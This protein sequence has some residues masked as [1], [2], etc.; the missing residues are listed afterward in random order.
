MSVAVLLAAA[1]LFAHHSFTAAYDS[2]KRVEIEGVVKEFVWRNPHSFVRIEV[3]T[4]EGATEL[5]NLE[6]GSTTQL[7]AAKYPVTTD[8]DQGRR[9]HHRGRR[10]GTRPGR[11]ARPHL[12]HQATD[13]RLGVGRVL[14]TDR[15]AG[16]L[17]TRRKVAT[18]AQCGTPRAAVL[19]GAPAST[20]RWRR[21][22]AVPVLRLLRSPARIVAP[23]DLTGYWVSVVAEHWHLRMLVPP[24]GEFAML[25]LNAEARK[26]ANAWDPAKEPEA[27][28]CKSYGAAAIMRVPGRLYIHWA[29][30]NTLQMDVDS[31]TQT[32]VFH[33]DRGASPTTQPPVAGIFSRG[34]GRNS[35]AGAADAKSWRTARSPRRPASDDHAHARGV[36]AQ[37]RRPL[38]R[39]RDARR[40]LRPL[41][42]AQRRRLDRRRQHRHRP[43]IPDAAVSHEQRVQ[44]DS[45]SIRLGSDALPGRSGQIDLPTAQTQKAP[46]QCPAERHRRRTGPTTSGYAITEATSRIATVTTNA[47]GPS[48]QKSASVNRSA[49]RASLIRSTIRSLQHRQRRAASYTPQT[50]LTCYTQHS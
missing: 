49:W 24:K 8:D 26:I 35:G 42:R 28:Q 45:R 44:E 16:S 10:T 11:Q 36:S 23:K 14:S 21:G 33:F 40:I 4:K 1:V 43:A 25:P 31:G 12:Q 41:H 34:M 13:R 7:Q 6:W 18:N 48:G 15:V 19:V 9:P 22:A 2:T 5:W 20:G 17:V 47:N 29:D 50:D 30:D 27:E 46:P 32:R 3:T 38:Q 37:E 39:K